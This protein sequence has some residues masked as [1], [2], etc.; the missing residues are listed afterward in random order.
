M[1]GLFLKKYANEF[2]AAN[3]FVNNAP[4]SET[5]SEK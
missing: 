2:L 5:M 1:L 4:S 3:H